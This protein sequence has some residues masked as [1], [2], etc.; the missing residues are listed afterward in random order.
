MLTY[1]GD[2]NSSF[3]GSQLS[4][5]SLC[6]LVQG[7]DHKIFPSV[8]AYLLIITIVHM[9]FV[10]PFSRRDCWTA[11]LLVFWLLQS[12]HPFSSAANCAI[13]AGALMLMYPLWVDSPWFFD[14]HTVSNHIFL[15]RSSFT[16]KTVFFDEGW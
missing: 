4:V 12:S 2:V 1:L 15:G 9:L 6:F 16:L 3:L 13:C 7:C 5:C 14:L 10:K 11:D 8:L